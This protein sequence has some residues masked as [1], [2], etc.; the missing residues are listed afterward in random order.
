MKFLVGAVREPPLRV[1]LHGKKQ[2]RRGRGPGGVAHSHRQAG[3]SLQHWHPV[4]P[5]PGL[6]GGAGAEGHPPYPAPSLPLPAGKL[7]TGGGALV[8]LGLVASM[9]AGSW[10]RLFI[11]LALGLAVYFLYAW[12]AGR[13]GEIA[14]A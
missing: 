8:C 11:W 1:D 10:L 5:F 7:A 6:P 14:P 12:R 13:L 4:Q 9:P 3:L 2:V